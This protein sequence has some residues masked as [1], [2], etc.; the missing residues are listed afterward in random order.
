MRQGTDK[1][2]GN[3]RHEIN[4]PFS[5]IKTLFSLLQEKTIWQE[6]GLPNCNCF[7]YTDLSL[8]ERKR[9]QGIAIVVKFSKDKFTITSDKRARGVPII[10]DGKKSYSK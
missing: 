10:L 6:G 3:K 2:H 1:R 9:F 5:T 4:S 8:I 7:I